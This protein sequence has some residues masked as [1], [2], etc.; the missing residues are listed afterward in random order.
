MFDERSVTHQLDETHLSKY[1]R[2]EKKFKPYYYEDLI[3][4]YAW[5]VVICVDG[6]EYFMGFFFF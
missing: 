2:L 4:S 3:G 6:L 5:A 1:E